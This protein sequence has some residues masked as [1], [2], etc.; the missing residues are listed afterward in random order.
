MIEQYP[1][2]PKLFN[3]LGAAYLAIGD[4]DHAEQVARENFE[5]F[6]DYLFAKLNYADVCMRTGKLEEV[7]VIFDDKF[8]LS[9]LY[10]KR[11]RFHVTEAA[12]FMGVMAFYYLKRGELERA[13]LYHKV[14]KELAPDHAA[15][16]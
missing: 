11:K 6:P 5:R 3:F 1:D 14:L 7:P 13:R 10:P 16:T 12:G 8:D 4:I 15:N 9:L 2:C